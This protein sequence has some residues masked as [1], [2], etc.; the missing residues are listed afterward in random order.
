VTTVESSAN[1]ALVALPRAAK[2]G[3]PPRAAAERLR[4]QILECATDAL[5]TQGYGATS[6]ESIAR[7]ARVSKRTFYHRFQDKPA[8]MFAV[9]ARLIDGLRPPAD[10]P[11]IEGGSLAEILVHLAQLVVRAA[12]S[13]RALQLHRLLVAE[14]ERFPELGQAVAR[15]GGRQEAIKLISTLLVQRGPALDGLRAEF[16]AQQF[17]QL[18][19]SYPQMRAIGLGVPMRDDELDAWVG[20]SVAL[21]LGGLGALAA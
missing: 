6:I 2:P 20:D 3:R 21:F 12:L 13:T 16:A 18:I 4:D 11:L 5:L 10:V 8:L 19:L 14:S 17:L 9:V 7:L 15:A 1:D